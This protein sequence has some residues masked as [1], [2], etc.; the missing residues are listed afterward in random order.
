MFL[1]KTS[2]LIKNLFSEL[3]L[4]NN[5]GLNEIAVFNKDFSE[6]F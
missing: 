5:I 4:L 3:M 2:S 1:L 6:V